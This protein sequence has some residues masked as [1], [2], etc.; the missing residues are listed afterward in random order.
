MFSKALQEISALVK[1]LGNAAS[2]KSGLELGEDILSTL[3]MES[4]GESRSG[5][6]QAEQFGTLL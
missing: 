4:V 1:R 2:E 5:V 3:G 6:F